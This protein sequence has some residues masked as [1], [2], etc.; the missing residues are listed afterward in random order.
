V[1]RLLI[2]VFLS[3]GIMTVDLALP[4]Q[5]R[6]EVASAVSFPASSRAVSPDGRYA[7]IDVDRGSQPYHTVFLKD[8]QLNTRRELFDY[9][10]HVDVLWN[11]DSTL[12]AVTDYSESNFSTCRIF[13]VI[14][15]IATTSVLDQLFTTLSESE[16]KTLRRLQ[17]NQH[18]YVAAST[19]TGPKELKLKVWGLGTADPK[20][21]T[22]YYPLHMQID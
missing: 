6:P 10:R 19:W 1:N 5:E 17:S 22:R 4:G 12:F 11:P 7:V 20:G 15:R 13:S 21:F 14:A 2:C 3:V 18:F 16:Q 9:D 8:L